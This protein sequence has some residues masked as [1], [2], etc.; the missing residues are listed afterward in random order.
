MISLKGKTNHVTTLLETPF[1]IPYHMKNNIQGLERCMS[2]SLFFSP[3]LSISLLLPSVLV[4]WTFQNILNAPCFLCLFLVH[5]FPHTIYPP[6]GVL[7]IFPDPAQMSLFVEYFLRNNFNNS[8][9]AYSSSSRST[10][11]IFTELTFQATNF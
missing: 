9:T 7:F 1:V 8:L 3:S 6:G 2:F 10:C 5:L 11:I 4:I